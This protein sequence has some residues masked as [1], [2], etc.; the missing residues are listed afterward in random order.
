M[1]CENARR[2]NGY[3]SDRISQ[4]DFGLGGG[5]ASQQ[6]DEARTE[7]ARLRQGY[8]GQPSGGLTHLE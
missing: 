5:T 3:R 6:V 7:V 2:L 1:P 4:A 8:G